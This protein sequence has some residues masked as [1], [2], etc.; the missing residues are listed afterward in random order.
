MTKKSF[1]SNKPKSKVRNSK[2]METKPVL[3]ITT[4]I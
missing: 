1:I 4:E 3:Y 2:T